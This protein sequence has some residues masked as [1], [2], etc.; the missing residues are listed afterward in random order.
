MVTLTWSG[1]FVAQDR[2]NY[3]GRW[4]LAEDRSTPISTPRSLGTT[5][6]IDQ[7]A[8][9]V[10]IEQTVMMAAGPIRLVNGQPPA[11]PVQRTEQVISTV[12]T[13]DGAEHEP[14]TTVPPTTNPNARV[15]VISSGTYR[16]T[17]TT[18]QL[19]ILTYVRS[20]NPTTREAELVLVRRLALSLDAEG[21]LIV[22]SV[23]VRTAPRPNG[24]K[25][26]PPVVV[27]SVYK[28][29]Q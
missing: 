23:S 26:E 28:K 9:T 17:W 6:K 1:A 27:R 16:A 3:S 13:A 15:M 14:P 19:V 20:M 2:P 21:S 29:T 25:E 22:D 11:E 8:T 4:T 5:F 7:S 18:G 10:T 24:P 12:Y